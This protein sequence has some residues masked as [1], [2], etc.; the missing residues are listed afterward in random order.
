[1]TTSAGSGPLQLTDKTKTF[2]GIVLFLAMV[3]Q[4]TAAVSW[5]HLPRPT[6]DWVEGTPVPHFV[7]MAEILVSLAFV[8][9]LELG[10]V[11]LL[12]L[13]AERLQAGRRLSAFAALA[14]SLLLGATA[15]Y[16]TYQGH[17][18]DSSAEQLSA[19]GF[20]LVTLIGYTV[21][22]ITMDWRESPEHKRAR[23]VRA[24]VRRYIKSLTMADA[25]RDVLLA[26]LDDS[27]IAK[28]ITAGLDNESI[29]ER[30]SAAIDP[31]GW[32]E[33]TDS[34]PE[35]EH[36]VDTDVN[37]DDT[38]V[39][40]VD[41][42][43]VNTPGVHTD[44]VDTGEA[45]TGDVYTSGAEV[46]LDSREVYT[47]VYIAS[48]VDTPT[49]E[50]VNAESPSFDA[51]ELLLLPTGDEAGRTYGQMAAKAALDRG[52]TATD[53]MRAYLDAAD[54]HG[55]RPTGSELAA[56]VGVSRGLGSRVLRNYETRELVDAA[57]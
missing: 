43:E 24:A 13:A 20:L 44:P 55:Y 28:D 10:A 14:A 4:F 17:W 49:D 9:V 57:S 50:S 8:I 26:T 33:S 48:E 40:S 32:R 31:S 35:S 34:A 53:A 29:A 42:D 1:M 46:A 45:S 23:A 30:L 16:I 5:V 38:E 52:E 47:P 56:A 19:A 25:D 21:A 18:G 54:Q 36:D 22:L 27:K 11:V 41:T 6:G 15:G 37:D 12:L 3:G 2:Y 51:P 7:T 39:D